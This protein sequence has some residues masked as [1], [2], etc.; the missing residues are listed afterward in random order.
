MK[1]WR[2]GGS[3]GAV[4]SGGGGGM[5]NCGDGEG[6]VKGISHL[7]RAG[8]GLGFPQLLPRNRL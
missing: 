1:V 5:R 8:Q 7:V 2:G 3:S 6:G 4:V